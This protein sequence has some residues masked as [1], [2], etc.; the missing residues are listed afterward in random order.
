MIRLP[1]IQLSIV[2]PTFNESQNVKELLHRIET[3]LGATGWEVIFV[4]DDSPDKTAS[5]VRDIARVDSRVRC[6]QRI[7]RRGLSSAVID[8]MLT[9]SA[10]RQN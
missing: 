2:V 3:T 7:D 10:V 4:D 6:L 8:G 1:Q 5:V 9:S